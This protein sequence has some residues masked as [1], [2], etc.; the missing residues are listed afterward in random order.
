MLDIHPIDTE[1][2]NYVKF[3]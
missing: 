2:E 1:D 3:Q